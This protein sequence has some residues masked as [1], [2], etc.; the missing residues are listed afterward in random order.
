VV[1]E[2]G[3]PVQTYQNKLFEAKSIVFNSGIE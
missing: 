2:K 3:K 1:E